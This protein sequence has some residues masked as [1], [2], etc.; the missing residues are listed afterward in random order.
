MLT[1]EKLLVL[2]RFDW[3]EALFLQEAA[4]ADK[5]LLTD[6]DW[7]KYASLRQDLTLTSKKSVSP[8]YTRGVHRQ[9]LAAC[10]GEAT[11]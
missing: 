7:S 1:V 3:D 6:I 5:A 8:E 2:L 11:A 9:L 10:V 4:P